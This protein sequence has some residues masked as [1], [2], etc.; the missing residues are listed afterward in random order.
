MMMNNN[1]PQPPSG[2][3]LPSLGEIPRAGSPQHQRAYL[4]AGW[5]MLETFRYRS[6]LLGSRMSNAWL[7]ERGWRVQLIAHWDLAALDA[8]STTP[9]IGAVRDM[10]A[11]S[12]L[13]G[14]FEP[15]P[16]RPA[17][18]WRMQVT[19]DHLGRFFEAHD[20]RTVMAFDEGR[21]FAIHSDAQHYAICC[22]PPWFV[23]AALPEGWIGEDA[24]D[25][26]RQD[27][28][29]EFGKGC[30]DNILEHYAPFMLD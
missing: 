11:N 20:G 27:V 16:D 8:N 1:L 24:T 10:G 14:V 18:I 21:S 28:E 7:G 12:L 29:V 3:V 19:P 15:P 5:L 13:G 6:G 17:A 9:L 30:L 4:D 22:G 26:L 2:A 25:Q 23:R